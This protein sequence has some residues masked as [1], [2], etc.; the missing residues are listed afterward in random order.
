MTSKEFDKHRSGHPGRELAKLLGRSQTERVIFSGMFAICGSV[1]VAGG[2]RLIWAG[3]SSYYALAGLAFVLVAVLIYR[4]SAWACWAVAILILTTL[5]W[6]ISE[7]GLDWWQLVPR[8]DLV[9]VLGAILVL[10]WV[11]RRHALS[12]EGVVFRSGHLA[13][14]GS[15]FA[16]GIIAIVALVERQHDTAG[17]LPGGN[18]AGAGAPPGAGKDWTAYGGTNAGD[19]YSTMDQITPQNVNQ[20]Q[21]TWTF[22]TRDVRRKGDPVE[23]TYEVTPLKIDDTLYLC[24]PHDLVFALDA[25][26]GQ[27]K[28]HYDPKDSTAIVSD[29][30]TSDVPRSFL[31]RHERTTGDGAAHCNRLH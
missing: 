30:A 6:A 11:A 4:G 17:D 31:F 13:L 7:V 12:A 29:H 14:A 22:H 21:K 10:P 28:W 27:E 23:T 19:R 25:E 15:L 18:L 2:S 24:T 5:I 9:V 3:G 16:C 20:L 8:G 26:T 1:L